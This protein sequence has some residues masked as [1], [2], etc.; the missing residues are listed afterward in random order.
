MNFGICFDKNIIVYYSKDDSEN[1]TYWAN[2]MYQNLYI[3]F[4]SLWL[5]IST[6]KWR[7]YFSHFT[8]KVM[9]ALKDQVQGCIVNT[10]WALHLSAGTLKFHFFLSYQAASLWYILWLR[11][12]TFYIFFLVIKEKT[13]PIMFY[14][15]LHF[16]PPYLKS[17]SPRMHNSEG[18]HTP[19]E[20]QYHILGFQASL[21]WFLQ[22]L[23]QR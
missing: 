10:L 14:S 23:P 6:L 7:Y 3:N 8:Y 11:G 2:N 9:E 5:R 16:P 22:W 17:A 1:T 15:S 20:A 12:Q 19:W 13:S 18:R 21:F 4:L